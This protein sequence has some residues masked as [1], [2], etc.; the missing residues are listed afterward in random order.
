MHDFLICIPSVPA[1][2]TA[3]GD[4]AELV[5]GAEGWAFA[6]PQWVSGLGVAAYAVAGVA[7]VTDEA[8]NVLE[9]GVAPVVADGRWLLVSVGDGVA[10]PEVFAPYVVAEGAREDGLRLPVGVVGLST[11]W[12]G[13]RVGV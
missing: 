11:A 13:M 4:W 10:L 12:A 1:A 6:L 9:A 3:I 2:A 7:P 5:D 8:G